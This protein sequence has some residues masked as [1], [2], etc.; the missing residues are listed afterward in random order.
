MRRVRLLLTFLAFTAA[1]TASGCARGADAPPP[2]AA[3]ATVNQLMRSTLFPNSNVIF[4]AQSNDPAAVARADDPA[5]AT[6]PLASAYGGWEA[7]ENSAL[8]LNEMAR[9]FE[10]PRQCANGNAAPIDHAIWRQALGELREAGR[11]SY[12]A[13]QAKDQDKILDAADKMVTACSTCHDKFRENEPRCT[14]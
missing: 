13:A 5:T 12:E 4:F 14:P 1:A 3:T 10:V 7:V 11:I 9:L 6:N 2:V 8:A